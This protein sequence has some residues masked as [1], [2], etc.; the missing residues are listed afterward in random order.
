M[1]ALCAVGETGISFDSDLSLRSATEAEQLSQEFDDEL[2]VATAVVLQAN[3]LYHMGQ[4][5]AAKN[6]AQ[7]GLSLA[8][9]LG[10]SALAA[11]VADILEQVSFQ[12]ESSTATVT[13]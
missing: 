11:E 12:P 13:A 9:Q 5:A 2:G 7:Q 10:A 3:I 6:K 1:G 8:E 4:N